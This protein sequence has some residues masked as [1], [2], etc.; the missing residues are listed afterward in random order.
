MPI[1]YPYKYLRA[2]YGLS[3]I[4]EHYSGWMEEAF[5]EPA[6]YHCVVDDVV[7]YDKYTESHMAHP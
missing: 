6:G 2:V 3:S 4:A 5:E 7:I 1:L